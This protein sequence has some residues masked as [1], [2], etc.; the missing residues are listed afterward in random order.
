LFLGRESVLS[1]NSIFAALRGGEDYSSSDTDESESDES[2]EV[3]EQEDEEEGEE[4][5]ANV[6]PISSSPVKVIIKTGLNSVLIDQKLELTCSRKRDVASLKTSISRQMPGRPPVQIQRLLLGAKELDDEMLLDDVAPEDEDEDDDDDDEN[7]EG[8]V[9]IQLTLDVPPPIDSK[10]AT[11]LVGEDASWRKM[12][13]MAILDAYV[14]NVAAMH[15]NSQSILAGFDAEERETEEEDDTDD[16]DDVIEKEQ[17]R[18][19]GSISATLI[20]R[21][22]ALFIKEQLLSTLSDEELASLERSVEDEAGGGRKDGR[23]SK[24]AAFKGGA[25]MNVKRALQ[26]NLNI[27]WADTIRNVLL[28]LFFGHFG[29]RDAVSRM[30]MLCGAPMCFILQARPVKILLKQLYYA[31]GKPPGIIL[32]LFPATQQAIMGLDV[33]QA[34]TDLYGDAVAGNTF[35]SGDEEDE[36]EDYD[37]ESY[38]SDDEE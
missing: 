11:E 22:H 38:D 29:A 23:E 25:K 20:M 28:L 4:E 13:S 9:K 24:N 27:N 1:K 10:F 5:V 3:E 2:D 6:T 16:D 30:I 37:N 18:E 21:K 15:Y 31:I 26:H 17:P 19:E 32:T 36:D 7:D 35:Q 8:M 12:T 33:D 14:A 34:L